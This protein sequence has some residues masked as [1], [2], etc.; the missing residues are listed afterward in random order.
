M[1][2]FAG[3]RPHAGPWF[4]VFPFLSLLLMLAAPTPA[5]ALEPGRISGRVVDAN[6]VPVPR[7]D[8]DL[9][10]L[11]RSI[12]TDRDGTFLLA[13][14]PPGHYH[15]LASEAR[16]GSALAELDVPEAG[17][18]R[19]EFRLDPGSH[20]EEVVVSARPEAQTAAESLQPVA[21]LAGADLALR[22]APTLGATLEREAGVAASSYAP[23]ASRPVIRGLGGERIRILDEGIGTGDAAGAS[24]DHAV[25]LDPSTAE[26]IEVVRGPAVLLYGSS[27]IGGV[28][29]VLGGRI[30]DRD[31]G[32]TVGGSVN[33]GGSTASD[34][35][36]SAASLGGTLGSIGW[37][38]SGFA[39][40]AG[41]LET[42]DG[43]ADNT[44]QEGRG[45]D[46][47]LSWI[48]ER[49]YIGASYS[50]FESLYGIPGSH[51]DEE[52]ERRAGRPASP[53]DEDEGEHG[54]D[55]TIDMVRDRFDVA[56][57][58]SVPRG[59]VESVRLRW[60]L[61]DYTH[62]ELEGA[63]VG[64]TYANDGWEGR[65][66]ARHRPLG[67]AS[68]SFGLQFSE[69]QLEARGE[70]AFVPSSRTRTSSAFVFERLGKGD[71]QGEVGLRWESQ[72]IDPRGD[73]L[74]TRDLDGLSASAGVVARF[75]GGWSLALSLIRSERLPSAQELFSDGPHAATRE[76]QLGDPGLDPET[77]LGGDLTLRRG[78][79]RLT[80][81]LTLFASR[82]ADFI[83][84]VP[85]GEDIDGLPVF[86]YEQTDA[87]FAGAELHGDLELLHAEPHHFN[88]ELT[89]DW[90][91]AESSDG[92]EPLARIPPPRAGLG[93]RYENQGISARVEMR[94]AG[95]QDRVAP[96]ETETDGYT[97]W[98]ASIGYRLV[99][100]ATVHDLL[101]RGENLTDELAR[102]HVS[103]LKDEL[104]LAG[105]SLAVSWR[106]GF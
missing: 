8:V 81:E 44:A 50:R 53:F 90:V 14:V 66:E 103:P 17:E 106:V 87:T 25:A 75:T 33:V 42:P 73:D 70:E 105:R 47:G 86:V 74:P 34:E 38:L 41:D 94:V 39:R 91:R 35:W 15:L 45:G 49:G 1:S 12:R 99:L 30:P 88:L 69:Q 98:S 28:V 61:V 59:F 51:G 55:V 10:E 23:G 22:A 68:G 52:E 65:I 57:E 20:R 21:I 97:L 32:S 16:K 104:P 63:E 100:G 76:Y 92:G 72:T 40:D 9:V 79:G 5:A 67:P 43:V 3:L 62:S 13:D 80:G 46:L 71:V 101:L 64:T 77:S 78:E 102:N 56:G 95:R 85:T 84:L 6:G 93:L 31:S 27:A 58:W 89:G 82:F 37:K 18:A 48:G 4:R 60:G 26:K 24:E 19:I 2:T 29:N 54:D 96:F 7:A 36:N 11:R 83:T